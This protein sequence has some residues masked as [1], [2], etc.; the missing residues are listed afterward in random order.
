MW[1]FFLH[2]TFKQA[3]RAVVAVM[4]GTVVVLGVVMLVTP[5]PALVVIPLGLAILATEFV[6]ARRVLKYVKQQARGMMGKKENPPPPL[7]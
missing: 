5:G 2:A 6:W 1:K 7:P 4:G 3:R